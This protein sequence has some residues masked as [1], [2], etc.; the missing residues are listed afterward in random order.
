MMYQEMQQS[1]AV[2]DYQSL[3]TIMKIP[4]EGAHTFLNLNGP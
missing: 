1:W 4:F 3:E 2:G